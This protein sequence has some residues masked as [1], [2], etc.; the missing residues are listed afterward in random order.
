MITDLLRSRARS[1][2]AT[3]LDTIAAAARAVASGGTGNVD[4]VEA[5]LAT[6]GRQPADFDAAVALARRRAEWLA[7]VDKL[8][9]ARSNLGKAEAALEIEGEKFLAAQDAY[10]GKANVLRF[11]LEEANAAIREGTT[12]RD[13]LLDPRNVPGGIAADYAEAV[14]QSRA[15]E[16]ARN[17]AESQL[18]EVDGKLSS[19]ADKVQRISGQK[20]EE[21]DPSTWKA[22]EGEPDWHRDG[23]HGDLESKLRQ[24]REIGRSREAIRE[25]LATA[26]KDFAT[27]KKKRD[28]MAQGVLKS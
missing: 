1:A 23:H 19:A 12:A 24:W 8:P 11:E 14:A 7:L 20:P 6:I 17:T 26:T 22:P 25:A 28:G 9:S 21:I 15:A 18:K 3:A 4:A 10:A 2:E 27:W 5:A 13:R 16:D